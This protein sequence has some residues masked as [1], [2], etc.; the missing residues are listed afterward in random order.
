MFALI[1]EPAARAFR[2]A[3]SSIPVVFLAFDYDPV[4]KGMIASLRRPGGNMTGVYVPQAALI[5][6][7]LEIAQEVL[8]GANRF[9]V[10]TDVHTKDQLAALRTAAAARR[11]QLTVVEY[12]QQPYDFPAGFEAGRRE[13]VDALILFFS[14][15]FTASRAKLSALFASYK[16]PVIVPGVMAANPGI[17]VSYSQNQAKIFRRAAEIGVQILKGTKAAEI[18]VEQPLEFDLVVNLKTA[19]ALG[20][21]IPYSVMARA[22]KVI[23]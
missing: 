12:A 18:P 3:R 22:T 14:P 6:K 20:V 21:K 11:V 19:K 17:L 8:P 15:E 16:L 7:R 1:S 13:K 2:D 23:E 5:A 9:L 10:L 4:E